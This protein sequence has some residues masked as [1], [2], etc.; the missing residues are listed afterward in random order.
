MVGTLKTPPTTSTKVGAHAFV[1]NLQKG[2]LAMSTVIKTKSGHK[3]VLLNP[4]EK[5]KRYAR[6]MKSGK[7][8]ETKKTLTSEQMAFRAGYLSAR[9]DAAKAYNASLRK[10]KR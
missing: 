3:V 7:V 5:A 9:S 2:E 4:A 10:R 1:Q 6:Q 8:T